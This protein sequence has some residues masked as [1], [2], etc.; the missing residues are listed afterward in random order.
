MNTP[1]I[2]GW[3]KVSL[4][5]YPGEISTILFLAGCNLRCPYC[6]NES[7]VYDQNKH[8]D[9]EE[10]QNWIKL[11]SNIIT[12]I[13]ITGGEPTI[14]PDLNIFSEYLNQVLKLKVKL[15]TNG[16]NPEMIKLINPDYLA[17]DIKAIPS[18]YISDFKIVPPTNQDL[19]KE[20]L[21]ESISIVKSMGN[22]AEI[23]ITVVPEF[24]NED[25]INYY[26]PILYGVSKVWIQIPRY[27]TKLIDKKV[28]QDR[29][30]LDNIVK[31]RDMLK[32]DV[33]N[34]S[35]REDYYGNSLVSNT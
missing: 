13:V 6:F 30:S 8:I 21:F 31:L 11:R 20:R 33:G 7:I 24:V 25:M 29:Y 3:Q 32:H 1:P 5:D 17:L 4:I 26:I 19:I 28:L 16:L 2:S 9:F 14:H 34:C 15:D 18:K 35:I 22:R 27:N 23:R 10:I 12:G